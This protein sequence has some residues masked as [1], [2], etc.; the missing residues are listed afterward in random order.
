[1]LDKNICIKKD[2]QFIY[3][4]IQYLGFG[5]I[6]EIGEHHII[7]KCCDQIENYNWDFTGK[8]FYGTERFYIFEDEYYTH[9]DMLGLIQDALD[10]RKEML[11]EF[12]SKQIEDGFYSL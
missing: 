11:Q 7:I 10:E 3:F 2:C 12:L 6:Q 8:H 4:R 1:M 9:K 5:C